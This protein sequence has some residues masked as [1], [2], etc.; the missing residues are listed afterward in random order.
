MTLAFSCSVM[1]A[2]VRISAKRRRFL[3]SGS[4]PASEWVDEP[5]AAGVAARVLMAAVTSGGGGPEGDHVV[6]SYADAAHLPA[7][8]AD[9]LNLP[10]LSLLSVTLAFNGRVESPDSTI[11]TRWFDERT[12]PV[13]AR[14]IGAFVEVGEQTS[15]LSSPLF[16]LLEAVDGFN[17]S[18]GNDFESR[19]NTWRPVQDALQRV[20]GAEV[21]TDGFLGSLTIYQAG[22]FALDA[23]ETA[24]GLDLV[25][26]LMGRNKAPSLDDN[27]PAENETDGEAPVGDLLDDSADA[28]LPPELQRR[29]V[30]ERFGTSSPT[31]DAYVLARNTF[32]VLDPDLKVALDVVRRTRSASPEARREFL[33]NPRP[34]IAAALGRED[35]DLAAVGLFVETKQY[36]ERVLGLGVWDPPKLPWLQK[37][38]EQWAPETFPVTLRGR[39]IE[40]TPERLDEIIEQ[41]DQAKQDA[42]PDLVIDQD[43]YSVDEVE[44][45]V[46]AFRTSRQEF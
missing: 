44:A 45:A 22:S 40:L 23:R 35:S 43:T 27:A 19:I 18:V 8:I 38:S 16:A 15:R 41:V 10:P 21:K 25:P 37:K 29:F 2:G 9:R 26:V 30:N 17:A 24:N 33:R 31:R 36:S 46:G 7:S 39:T 1:P 4:V 32:V 14:R 6:L 3:R 5:G 34:A 42:R 12:R 11:Q 20:T 28:L 13:S